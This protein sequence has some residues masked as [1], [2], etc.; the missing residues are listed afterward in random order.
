MSRF[1]TGEFGIGQLAV[2]WLLMCL[3]F[4]LL[5]GPQN[6]GQR[7]L[8]AAAAGLGA[9]LIY[10]LGGML[11]VLLRAPA[12]RPE[13]PDLERGAEGVRIQP[14]RPAADPPLRD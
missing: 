1:F 8:L 10:I 13:P 4:W 14:A 6:R 5:A 9:G 3:R 2:L 12:A 11:L 7:H